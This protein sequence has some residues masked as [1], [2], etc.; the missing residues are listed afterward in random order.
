M[1]TTELY[2]ERPSNL[3]KSSKGVTAAAVPLSN[4]NTLFLLIMKK[5]YLLMGMSR[6]DE[7]SRVA[8]IQKK[9]GNN[10]DHVEEDQVVHNVQVHKI[11]GKD[12]NRQNQY[13]RLAN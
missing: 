7:V 9:T 6:R 1:I 4:L 2:M 12:I 11:G 8:E 5:P 13:L 10:G 3:S